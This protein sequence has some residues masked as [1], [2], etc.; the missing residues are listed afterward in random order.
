M[1]HAHLVIS[2][3]PLRQSILEKKLVA[4]EKRINSIKKSTTVARAF[5]KLAKEHAPVTMPFS[6]G[7]NFSYG[8]ISM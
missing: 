1:V 7:S 6:R 8:Y 5:P 3:P 4:L 2:Y